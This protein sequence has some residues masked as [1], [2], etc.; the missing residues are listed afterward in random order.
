MHVV[1]SPASEADVLLLF[2]LRMKGKYHDRSRQHREVD[3]LR[4]VF[5]AGLELEYGTATVA[6]AVNRLVCPGSGGLAELSGPIEEPPEFRTI[7]GCD[8]GVRVDPLRG[9]CEWRRQAFCSVRCAET[10]RRAGSRC[11]WSRGRRD[12]PS[13]STPAP[14]QRE[15]LRQRL[16]LLER[17]ADR[18][19]VAHLPHMVAHRA[20]DH[21]GGQADWWF[22]V[23]PARDRRAARL[24]V[25]VDEDPA[26][27][28]GPTC[29]VPGT[30]TGVS[31]SRAR[32]SARARRSRR[33]R[34]RGWS[35]RRPR[36]G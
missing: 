28:V 19:V 1:A 17:G 18:H 26:A 7:R 33:C 12:L 11:K 15:I 13:R 8:F 27:V 16:A 21:A 30:S 2:G 22:W 4:S 25:V 10:G 6:L 9:V 3:A 36:A 35:G 32:P 31:R 34:G 29:E 5:A 20:P 14:T 24:L 23:G